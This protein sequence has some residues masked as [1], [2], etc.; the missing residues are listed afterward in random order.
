MLRGTFSGGDR[1]LH[2]KIPAGSQATGG[3]VPGYARTSL[4]AYP[5]RI[6]ESKSLEDP[7]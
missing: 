7:L 6:H 4:W 2:E 1:R 5:L 3:I